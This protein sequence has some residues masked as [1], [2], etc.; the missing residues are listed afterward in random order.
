MVDEAK[1]CS[2]VR[3]P[4]E[5]LVVRRG[6]A[7]SWGRIGPLSVTPVMAAG[8][9]VFGASRRLAEHTCQMQWFHWDSESCGG[10]DPATD[11]HSP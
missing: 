4:F 9:A 7:L 10:S 3:S 6:R 2:P 11:H 1:H 5:A 8:V